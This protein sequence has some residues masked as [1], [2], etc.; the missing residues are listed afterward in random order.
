MTTAAKTRSRAAGRSS[1][2][3]ASEADASRRAFADGARF[4][5]Q[6]TPRQ[7]P[8]RFLYDALGSALFDAICHLPWYR[9]TRGERRLLVRH[10]REIGR[11]LG[12][13]GRVVELGCGNGEKLATLLTHAGVRHPRAHLIDLS[14]S[15][16]QHA[17]RALEGLDVRVTTHHGTYD[18]GL[19]ALPP[20]PAHPTLLAFLGSNIGNFDPPGASALLGV[21]RGALRPGDALL[22]GADLVKP[23][24][25]LLLAYAD[26]LGLTAAFNKNLLVRLNT[27]LGA[28]F[29]L[30]GFTHR[31]VWNRKASRVEMHLVSRRTQAVA[32]PG[33][34]LRFTLAAGETI[35]T[36]SSYKYQPEDIRRLAEA[37]A[38]VQ[39]KQW[40][41]DE[42]RFA[43]T[44]FEAS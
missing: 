16:L 5:L 18:E 2:G 19:L 24:R 8:S 28:D 13:G 33:A 10:A 26:P 3:Q 37:G 6:Q 40:I 17:A 27:E 43:L 11:A 21:M 38:F 9:I 34:G 23:E 1:A 39:R 7:L 32:V 22:L 42:A 41:D 44:L 14:G 31:A 25:D 30:D 12:A 15:A 35:W 20:E 36:E 4:Y 29:A